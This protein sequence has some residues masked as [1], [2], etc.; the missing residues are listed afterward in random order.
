[1]IRFSTIVSF[2][3]LRYYKMNLAPGVQTVHLGRAGPVSYL[4]GDAALTGCFLFSLFGFSV[5]GVRLN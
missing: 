5:F 1:M 3:G 2:L 4:H